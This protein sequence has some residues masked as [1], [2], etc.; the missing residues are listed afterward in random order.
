MNLSLLIESWTQET[1]TQL[2]NGWSTDDYKK[3]AELL[4]I[5]DIRPA[6]LRDYVL[7]G[8]NDLE[9]PEATIMVLTYLVGDALNEGQI[10]N[11]AHEL[12]EEKLWEEYAD[13]NLHKYLF[14]AAELLYEAFNGGFP[15][16]KAHEIHLTLK[17][18]SPTSAEDMEQLSPVAILRLLAA[19]FNETSLMRR[20]FEKELTSGAFPEAEGIVWYHSVKT[21]APDTFE[22]V[23]GSSEYWF[24]DFAAVESFSIKFAM[25]Q[26]GED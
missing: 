5:S 17:P 4:D 7:L 15:H 24:E 10:Q 25:E 21:T 3:L 20:L 2:P 9:R 6:E 12:E 22:L 8:L 14:Q 16:P 18:V 26:E 19:G 11:L 13:I 1:I 23:V